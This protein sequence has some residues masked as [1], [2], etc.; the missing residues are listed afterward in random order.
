MRVLFWIFSLCLI[1]FVFNAVSQKEQI[2]G[3]W[4]GLADHSVGVITDITSAMSSYVEGHSP[5]PAREESQA[6]APIKMIAAHVTSTKP[7]ELLKEHEQ[8]VVSVSVP[9]VT[10]QEEPSAKPKL[11]VVESKVSK[12]VSDVRF[13]EVEPVAVSTT[14]SAETMP[15]LSDEDTELMMGLNDTSPDHD[16]VTREDWDLQAQA[17]SEEAHRLLDQI[18]ERLK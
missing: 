1:L 17:Y 13:E 12:L 14:T 6:H 18:S 10:M 7:H 4:S 9:V 5:K 15:G 8:Q 11:A 16:L 3:F 2:S